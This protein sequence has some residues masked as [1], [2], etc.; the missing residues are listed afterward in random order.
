MRFPVRFCNINNNG[1]PSSIIGSMTT[2]KL[3]PTKDPLVFVGGAQVTGPPSKKPK[4]QWSAGSPTD[5]SGRFHAALEWCLP[6]RNG[7]E[8]MCPLPV[9]AIVRQHISTDLVRSFGH[10]YDD[11]AKGLQREIT[12]LEG[13]GR[14]DH[15]NT[16][17]SRALKYAYR[18]D[19]FHDWELDRYFGE[20]SLS[21]LITH[22]EQTN[23]ASCH[24]A[25]AN[26]RRRLRHGCLSYLEENDDGYIAP[27]QRSDVW[28]D[29]DSW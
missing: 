18:P 11:N 12:H 17:L 26:L 8:K 14:D 20:D 10:L 24:A 2:P 1:F 13:Q 5:L 9:K 28:D 25:G 3:E 4:R 27:D 6:C 15:Y 19:L 21:E 29:S 16:K 7:E 23:D 22:L